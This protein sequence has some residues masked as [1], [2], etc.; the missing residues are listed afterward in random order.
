M[1]QQVEKLIQSNRLKEA[2][3]LCE[4]LSRNHKKN[5]DVWMLLADIYQ[6]SGN[7][8]KAEKSY[9]RVI[10]LKSSYAPAHA[11]LAMLYHSQGKFTKA[12]P[13]Y[14][15]SLK[16][17]DNQPLVHFNFGVVLQELGKQEEAASQYRLA[18]KLKNDYVKAYANLGYILRQQKNAT[19]AIDCYRQALEFSPEVAN[20]HYNLGW[21][22]LDAGYTEEA[23]RHQRLAIN[24]Q[25]DYADAWSGLGAVQF[26][27]DDIDNAQ[28]SYQKAHD[29]NANDVDILCGYSKTLSAQS[30]REEAMQLI[31]KALQIAPENIQANVAKAEIHM[32]MGQ[33]DKSLKCCNHILKI[34]P[35]HEEA[36][37]IAASVCEK[38]GNN[39]QAY[40][41]LQPLLQQK[42]CNV[43]AILIFAAI[44]KSQGLESEAIER[45]QQIIKSDVAM[46]STQR[47]K[48]HFTLGKIYDGM[49]EY[50]TAFKHFET[51]NNLKQVAFDILSFQKDINRQISVF[52]SGFSNTLPTASIRSNRPIFIVGMPRSGTS[53]LE[54]ILSSH[55]EVAAAGELPVI[56]RLAQ[57]LP[58]SNNTNCYYADCL[59]NASS[60]QLDQI[61]QS[62]L[63]HL[64][65]LDSD[66]PH[67]TD[68]MPSNFMHLGL[69]QLL[70]P[71]ARIIHC[72][73]NP[74]DTC[75]SCYFQDFS[76]SHPWIYDLEDTANVYLE[77]LRL[78]QHWNTVLEI[79][80]LNISY[81]NLV[82]N[83]QTV[84]REIIEFCGLNW[85]DSCLEF[86]K[87]KRF[88]KTASYNQVRQ[89]M[90]NKSVE[91]WRNY[92]KHLQPLIDRLS[93]D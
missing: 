67:I 14:R 92:E 91:R 61:A 37:N 48:L 55:P 18:I 60:Q 76:G 71:D 73:R 16:S 83:Q 10:K 38:Q 82:E 19:D 50:D 72:M 11:G 35:Q 66:A 8:G 24:L 32:A 87:N 17:G 15:L 44:S 36:I 59:E 51:G 25:P 81:E 4:Q 20:I 56:T 54:Q 45:I 79:P 22:L 85:D 62:Y 40:T 3:S 26:F 74:I 70:F 58:S 29:L 5:L 12:E 13:C 1:L 63:E 6:R 34:T 47:R 27:N 84:S 7:T 86:H 64:N 88:A 23:E 41:Y 77:Y 75:L 33:L 78:M 21:A 30:H 80:V 69:I 65:R 43:K 46:Q 52:S 89:P 42:N 93:P 2:L 90:Y 57:S 49:K 9:R 39:E 28:Y 53:L 31:V 68:K